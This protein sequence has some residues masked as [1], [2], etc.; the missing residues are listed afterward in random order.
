M[1]QELSSRAE[2]SKAEN[3]D[4]VAAA[5]PGSLF[6]KT[7]LLL[8]GWLAGS[9]PT[10]SP[11]WAGSCWEC[12]DPSFSEAVLANC[13]AMPKEENP[14]RQSYYDASHMQHVQLRW[15]WHR[16]QSD[17][18]A[19]PARLRCRGISKWDT[20]AS[21]TP[22]TA[23]ISSNHCNDLKHHCISVQAYHCPDRMSLA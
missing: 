20:A 1:Q 16:M 2:S 23:A 21:R 5:E 17:S 11:A 14:E 12:A 10:S 15:H 19:P 13:W 3:R 4:L 7:V 18:G 22:A 8:S 9:F 6:P